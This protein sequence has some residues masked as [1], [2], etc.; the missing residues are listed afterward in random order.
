M[1][2]GWRRRGA[3]HAVRFYVYLYSLRVL[4]VRVEEGLK[5]MWPCLPLGM[6]S[7]V[8]GDWRMREAW[9]RH[10]KMLAEGRRTA[11]ERV[12]GH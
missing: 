11:W 4:I 2:I 7:K 1:S 6:V 8:A 9:E 3:L 10:E 12:M 5:A